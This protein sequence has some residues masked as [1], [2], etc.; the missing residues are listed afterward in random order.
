LVGTGKIS[1][2]AILGQAGGVWASTA[3]FTVQHFFGACAFC[4]YFTQ[5]SQLSTT[6]QAAIVKAFDNADEI[7]AK[8]IYLAGEKHFTTSAGNHTIQGKKKVCSLALEFLST[9]CFLTD[10]CQRSL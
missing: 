1:K 3:G 4:C 10:P 8:G 6:E 5:I 9:P 2:A 7:Q